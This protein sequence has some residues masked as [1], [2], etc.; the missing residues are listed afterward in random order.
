MDIDNEGRFSILLNDGR[1]ES[2]Q[3]GEER[4][5]VSPPPLQ[6]LKL[7]MPLTAELDQSKG[8]DFSD[9]MLSLTDRELLSYSADIHT[10]LVWRR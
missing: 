1:R 2:L 4:F 8:W 6:K 9:E 5:S 7:F 10:A 3:I